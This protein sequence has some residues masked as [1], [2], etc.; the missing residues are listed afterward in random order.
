MSWN[1]SSSAKENFQRARLIEARNS[2]FNYYLVSICETNLNATVDFPETLLNGYT[3]LPANNPANKKHG[4]VWIFYKNSL[5]GIVRD[6]FS[7]D[8]SIWVELKFGRKK[9]SL[10]FCIVLL[11]LSIPLL[12]F[13]LLYPNI[14]INK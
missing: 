14:E 1:V 2:I 5:P 7:F 3:I 11:L 10:L 6:N 4:G 9:Y 13:K 12:N 8:E